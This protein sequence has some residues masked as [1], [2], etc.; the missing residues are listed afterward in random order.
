MKIVEII[1]LKLNKLKEKYQNFFNKRYKKYIVEYKIED[2]KIKIFS[3]TG[4]YRIVKNTKSNIVSKSIAENKGIANYRGTTRITKDAINSRATIKCD[5]ILIDSISKSDTFPNNIV[6]NSSS[7]LEHEATVSKVSEEELF[8]LTSKG[9][10][11]DQ[12]KELIIMG[13]VQEFKKELPMEYAVELN[14]LLKS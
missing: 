1:K 5:T 3:S 9:L 11:M 6:A 14:R 10:T 8:Y 7:I 13:F 12:A 4:D 2:D